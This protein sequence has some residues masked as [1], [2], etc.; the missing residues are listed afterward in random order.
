MDKVIK[1][2]TSQNRLYRSITIT[3]SKSKSDSD[4]FSTIIYGGIACCV[5]CSLF[6][7]AFCS[8][9]SWFVQVRKCVNLCFTG[10]NIFA[11]KIEDFMCMVNRI[12]KL[13]SILNSVS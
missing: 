13:D 11:A 8:K 5:E 6:E 4:V 2:R 1:L 9:Q 12:S 3:A 10:T 7:V